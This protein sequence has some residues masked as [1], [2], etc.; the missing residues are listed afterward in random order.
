MIETGRCTWSSNAHEIPIISTWDNPHEWRLPI[1]VRVTAAWIQGIITAKIAC[2]S[3]L[4]GHGFLGRLSG[5]IDR[6]HPFKVK[7]YILCYHIHENISHY[8]PM[9]RFVAESQLVLI[10][11][12]L[13]RTFCGIVSWLNPTLSGWNPEESLFLTANKKEQNNT[14]LVGGCC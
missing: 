2:N 14:F 1:S 8:F 12:E 10:K 11:S 7:T 3:F 4:P 5:T 6:L 9:L 13:L